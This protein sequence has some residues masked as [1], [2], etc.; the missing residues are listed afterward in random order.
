MSLTACVALESLR[1]FVRREHSE[2]N[3]EFLIAVME[4]R[5]KFHSEHKELNSHKLIAKAREI[6]HKYIAS[7]VRFFSCDRLVFILLPLLLL[8]LLIGVDFG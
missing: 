2:E 5:K 1:S 6:F 4:F 3:V 8:K 7:D